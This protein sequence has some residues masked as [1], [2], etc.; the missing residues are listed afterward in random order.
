M[1]M[2]PSRVREC[3]NRHRPALCT[4]VHLTDPSVCEL[5]S[6]TGFDCLWVDIEHHGTSV[7]TAARMITAAR[8][9]GPADVMARPAKGEFMRMARLLEVG[10][11]GICYPRCDDEHEAAEVVRWA[12][13]APEGE[14]GYEGSNASNTFG[15]AAR[16]RDYVE[17]ANAVTWLA[18]QIESPEA[19]ER[20]GAIAQVPGI[21]ML[22]F[23]PCDYSLLAGRPLCDL[24]DA[25][26]AEA[27]GHVCRAT[28]SSGRHFGTLVFTDKQ[29]RRMIDAGATFLAMSS[30]LSMV[31]KGLVDLAE[32]WAALGLDLDAD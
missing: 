28:L 13:F 2:R 17:Q 21:D 4:A 29:A 12:K 15:A 32:R 1:A 3:W 26:V 9:G 8:A 27:A 16:G 10:A 30:D 18:V 11:T 19:A 20:A 23:G 22:F 24:D 6:A 14:R 7:Q 5:A 31:R 25:A